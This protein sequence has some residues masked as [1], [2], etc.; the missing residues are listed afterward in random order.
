MTA[1][2]GLWSAFFLRCGLL[3]PPTLEPFVKLGGWTPP[4]GSLL[5]CRSTTWLSNQ[6]APGYIWVGLV[7]H[8]GI[9]ANS[10][11]EEPREQ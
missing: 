4:V 10:L 6:P 1:Q 9:T 5:R 3:I 7:K 11:D 8:I 2:S